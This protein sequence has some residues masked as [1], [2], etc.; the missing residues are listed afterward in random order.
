MARKRIGDPSTDSRVTTT[1]LVAER[2]VIALGNEGARRRVKNPE[3]PPPTKRAEVRASATSAGLGNTLRTRT[4][5]CVR[6]LNT[7]HANVRSGELRR[8]RC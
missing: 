6:V 1:T 3:I 4:V 8:V 7:V 2:K 5:A